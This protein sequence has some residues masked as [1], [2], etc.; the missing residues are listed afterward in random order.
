MTRALARPHVLHFVDSLG[1]G[2][3]ECTLVKLAERTAEHYRHSVCAVRELGPVAGRLAELGVAIHCLN[4]AP[5]QKWGLVL[6][7]ARLCRTVRPDLVHTRNWGTIEGVLAARLAG[8]SAV[9]HGEYGRT[10]DDLDA[11]SKKRNRFTWLAAS[12]TDQVVAVSEHLREWLVARVGLRAAKVA[13][14]HD[15]VDTVRF[16]PYSG[17]E[18]RTTGGGEFVIA[19]VARLDPIK[20]HVVLF[21]ALGL[22]AVRQPNIRVVI[23]GDG[24]EREALRRD[25]AARQL[26]GRVRFLGERHDIP[27]VLGAADMFVLPSR[28][29]G[30]SNAILEAMAMGLP[31]VATRVGGNPEVVTDGVTGQLVEPNDA[32]ALARAIE[33][34]AIDDHA[35][36]QHGAAGRARVLSE[37]AIEHTVSGYTTVYR[38]ALA[39][40]A[41]KRTPRVAHAVR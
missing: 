6:R 15:G 31:V 36:R 28:F 16:Q 33:F 29:E 17:H 11:H 25:V 41:S 10:L 34:Y 7:M 27:S 4:K 39:R 35:R 14:I 30:I 26:D 37:Y 12:L 19:M 23:V 1:F 21:E 40:H 5:G 3:P 38:Q 20:G 8:V 2:G 13:V 24:S 22:L 9:V 32:K 18:R